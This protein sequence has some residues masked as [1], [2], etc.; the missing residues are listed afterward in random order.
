M[1]VDLIRWADVVVES[2]T[3]RAMPAWNLGYEQLKEINPSI[4]MLSTCL[5]GQDGPL[6]G[7]AGYGNLGAALSGF[8]SLAGWPDRSPAGPYLAYTD[9]TS[10]HL[11][12]AALMA[13]IDHRRRT[14][15]GC[16]LDGAQSE[17]ALHFLSPALVQYACNG[18][19]LNRMG[20]ED[21]ELAPHGLYPVA[22]D[23]R[24]VAVA[25]QN[26]AVWPA[27][28]EVI[29]RPDLAA[30]PDLATAVGR[31][32]RRH[33]LDDELAHWSAGRDGAEVEAAFQRAGVAA[34]RLVSD[35]ECVDDPQLAARGHFVQF[36]HPL[37]RRLVENTRVRCSRTPGSVQRSSPLL[38]EHTFEILTEVLGYDGDR[39]ADLAAAE[40]LE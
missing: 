11:L 18:D 14:G 40:A 7:M 15:E 34:H 17:A 12:L 30:Q 9:Y 20:N 27:W 26:D 36:D 4:I 39:I 5:F 23:D 38:G 1:L 2:F 8:F 19:I 6:S 31:H 24:W 29:G 32:A 21:R 33:E 37:G 3:P 16:Y 10:N 13:A 25:C 28:C 35:V 22:G